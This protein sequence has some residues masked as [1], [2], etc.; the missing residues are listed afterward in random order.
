MSTGRVVVLKLLCCLMWWSAVVYHSAV[1]GKPKT[2]PVSALR[3]VPYI[4]ALKRR[5]FTAPLVNGE[6]VDMPPAGEDPGSAGF[7]IAVSLR[8]HARRTGQGRAFPDGVGFR[9]HLPH[10]ESVSPDAAYH[11]GPRMGRRV[12]EGAPIFAVEVRSDNDYGRA[13]E[14]QRRQKRADYFACG[15]L[16]VSDVDVLSADVVQVYRASDPDHPTIYRRGDIAKA[17]PAVPGVW[18]RH[19]QPD[20]RCSRVDGYFTVTASR[21]SKASSNAVRLSSCGLPRSESMR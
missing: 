3:S 12:A 10:H 14:E 19:I 7:A 6:I 4:S 21:R 8:E 16:V 13:A 5:S 17:E 20:G 11:I 2:K 1:R 18:P 9:V 15:T